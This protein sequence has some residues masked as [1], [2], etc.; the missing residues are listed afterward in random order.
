MSKRTEFVLRIIAGLFALS[1]LLL[2]ILSV[3]A[4]DSQKFNSITGTLIAVVLLGGPII[5][6]IL[7]TRER[8]KWVCLTLLFAPFTL[9]YLALTSRRWR[10]EQYEKQQEIQAKI[11]KDFVMERLKQYAKQLTSRT[12]PFSF[13]RA[14]QRANQLY[15]NP[16]YWEYLIKACKDEDEN[17]RLVA[18]LLCSNIK[19]VDLVI[20]HIIEAL[21]DPSSKVRNNALY[22]LGQLPDERRVL[23]IIE[24]LKDSNNNI[25]STAASYLGD[26]GDQRAIEPLKEKLNDGDK[27]V[28]E[29]VKEALKKLSAD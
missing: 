23:P 9:G 28:R 10:N 21:K 29:A 12:T 2:L 13:V 11:N 4:S 18:V 8:T 22:S 7:V 20:G 3:K 16:K 14:T 6:G 1:F 15:Q 25:R 24:A 26:I 19:N 17:I 5:S 27:E